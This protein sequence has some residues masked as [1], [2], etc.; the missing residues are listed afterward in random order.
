MGKNSDI[1]R[2]LGF[3]SLKRLTSSMKSILTASWAYINVY[4]FP[5][6]AEGGVQAL[7]RR[8]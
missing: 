1:L 2:V 8:N 4:I 7:Q 5:Q 6:M 3:S